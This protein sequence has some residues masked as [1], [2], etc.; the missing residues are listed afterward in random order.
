MAHPEDEAREY[1]KGLESRWPSVGGGSKPAPAARPKPRPSP[2][3]VGSQSVADDAM[4]Q[5]E[6]LAGRNRGIAKRARHL[7]EN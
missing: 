1:L 7:R 2:A 6:R 3:A 5:A 4:A